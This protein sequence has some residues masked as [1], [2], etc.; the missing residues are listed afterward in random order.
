MKNLHVNSQKLAKHLSKYEPEKP[1]FGHR[2]D[3]LCIP[4]CWAF[5]VQVH[6]FGGDEN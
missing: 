3:S 6:K 1:S 5:S 4:K 2:C